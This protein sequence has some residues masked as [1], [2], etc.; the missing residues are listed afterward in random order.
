MVEIAGP[1]GAGKNLLADL[2]IAQTQEIFGDDFNCAILT[3]EY[4]YDKLRARQN[5]VQIALTNDE[6]A[7]LEAA[8]GEPLEEEEKKALQEQVGEFYLV[9]E[10]PAE[11]LI[12]SLLTLM[13]SG[14]IQLVI[15][16][17]LANLIPDEE[18]KK[19]LD[20]SAQVAA[21]ASMLTR[22]MQKIH[23]LMSRTK[24]MVIALNQVRAPIG[25]RGPAQYVPK[26]KLS[27]PFAIRH[28]IAGRIEI[29][30]GSA[31]K[32]GEV[33]IGKEL[34]WHISKG[35]AGFHEGPL[36]ILNYKYETGIEIEEDFVE[37]ILPFCERSGTWFTVPLG[38]QKDLRVQGK[39]RLVDH[40]MANPDW[41]E[42][43]K[44][45]VYELKG[46]RFLY[47]EVQKETGD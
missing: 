18:I 9:E 43:V 40:A 19:G 5:G 16:D 20:E 29:S 39:K 11:V 30:S 26:Y 4:K 3:A 42:S 17:S 47:R 37:T 8:Q 33:R 31:I 27:E 41:V 32:E 38:N 14:E 45:D 13:G 2:Y 24:T 21:R 36:G 1:E 7:E 6:I 28:G 10:G 46:I 15:I 22:F 44:K 25:Y 35:K 12:D 34:R 23:P